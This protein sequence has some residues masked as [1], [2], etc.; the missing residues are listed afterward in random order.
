[1]NRILFTAEE[2]GN[3]LPTRDPRAQHLLRV[4]K[5]EPGDSVEI[6]VID[7][8]IGKATVLEIAATGVVLDVVLAEDGGPPLLPVTCLLGHP[9]PIVLKRILRDLSAVGVGEILVCGTEL[10]ERSYLE[11]ALWHDQNFLRYL[12]EGASQAAATALPRVRTARSVGQAL[13]LVEREEA[14]IPTRLF[15]DEGADNAAAGLAFPHRAQ[16]PL[17][18]AIG[19][20]RGWTQRERT[21]FLNAGWRT[22]GLGPRVLRVETA[23]VAA[24]V[25]CASALYAASQVQAG[26]RECWNTRRRPS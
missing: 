22:V 9:R 2:I 20:E 1:M 17:I 26:Q 15:F 6:G 16:P 25:M 18:Y 13:H 21:L 12:I 23:A 4:L 8:V 10:G 7:G 24:A 5:V 14:V 3:P 11:S 19:S